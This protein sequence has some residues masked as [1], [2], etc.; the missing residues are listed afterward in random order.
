[1]TSYRDWAPGLGDVYAVRSGL[2]DGRV[3]VTAVT[4]QGGNTVV[5]HTQVGRVHLSGCSVEWDEAGQSLWLCDVRS[6][7]DSVHL[8]L[9]DE[10]GQYLLK[11]RS[12]QLQP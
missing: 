10:I 5:L 6:E 11:G 12:V 7:G 9:E 2:R 4:N 8:C 1:M 3:Q